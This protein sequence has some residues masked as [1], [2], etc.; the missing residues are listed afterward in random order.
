MKTEY[1]LFD[2]KEKSILFNRKPCWECYS[3]KKKHYYGDIRYM[4]SMKGYHFSPSELIMLNTGF[5]DDMSH[6]LKQLNEV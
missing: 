2:F 3:K 5:L 4:K 1:E 6:F